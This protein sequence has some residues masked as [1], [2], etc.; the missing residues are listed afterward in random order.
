MKINEINDTKNSSSFIIKLENGAV[1][2]HH[3]AYDDEYESESC[4]IT[5]SLND[6]LKGMEDLKH[7][8]N[9]LIKGNYGNLGIEVKNDTTS[10]V[11]IFIP[12][13]HPRFIFQ[14]VDY[15]FYD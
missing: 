8:K 4:T 7:N 2:L 12:E 9:C 1:Q 3:H 14:G 15:K 5:F 10:T 6:Y 13:N 11:T